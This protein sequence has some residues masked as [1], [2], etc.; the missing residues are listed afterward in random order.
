[1]S[2]APTFA[3]EED[4]WRQGYQHI[5]G[6]DE[7]GRG[8]LAGP[9]VAAAVILSIQNKPFWLFQVRDSKKLSPRKRE[10]LS[11]CIYK[12]ALAVGIG[13][14]PSE[15]I[16]E[17]G[18]VASTKL[19]M[20]S[21]VEELDVPP[22]FLLI[23]ALTLSELDMPQKG[24]IKGDNLSLSIAAASIVA[25]VHRDRLMEEYDSSYPGYSF[26]RHKGYPTTEHLKRLRH[27]GCCPIHRKSFAPVRKGG[28]NDR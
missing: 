2:Q 15:T 20:C 7:V 22:D 19:A 9:V 25:K 14:V 3:E 23:D 17:R 27:L 4:L 24:I 21:A 16:D 12:E 26:A 13:V 6:I 10:F 18:I 5:A 8:P 28:V 1:M 11:E